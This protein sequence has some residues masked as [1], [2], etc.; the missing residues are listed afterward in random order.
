VLLDGYRA[1]RLK[2]KEK[3]IN[4]HFFVLSSRGLTHSRAG[5]MLSGYFS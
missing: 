1:F 3:M 4:D 5:R 2:M